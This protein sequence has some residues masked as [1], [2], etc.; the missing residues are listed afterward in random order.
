[1]C[2]FLTY[3]LVE[4]NAEE[5]VSERRNKILNKRANIFRRNVMTL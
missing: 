4:K 1:M 3:V 2:K 5:F